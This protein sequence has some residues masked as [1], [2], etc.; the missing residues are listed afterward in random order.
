MVVG[1]AVARARRA[2][3]ERVVVVFILMV[4]MVSKMDKK[5]VMKNECKYKDRP[6]DCNIVIRIRKECKE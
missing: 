5:Y 4:V 3:M 6:K 1:R 2:K